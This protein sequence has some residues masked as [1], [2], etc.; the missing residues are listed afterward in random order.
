MGRGLIRS[1][2]G[3]EG[4]EQRQGDGYASESHG[5]LC[6]PPRSMQGVPAVKQFWNL[7]ELLAA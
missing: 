2:P 5:L 7:S 1:V 3:Q 6:S 4:Q